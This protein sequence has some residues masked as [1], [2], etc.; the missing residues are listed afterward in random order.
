VLVTAAAALRAWNGANVPV[1][2]GHSS[3]EKPSCSMWRA[4]AAHSCPL[5]PK[6]ATAPNRNLRRPVIGVTSCHGERR[7][8]QVI[9]SRRTRVSRRVGIPSP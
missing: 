4:F 7:E 3:V 2:S 5:R 1:P 6:A 8:K 9:G